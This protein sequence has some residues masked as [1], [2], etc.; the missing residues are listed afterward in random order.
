MDL[1]RVGGR[2]RRPLAQESVDQP[3]A[4]DDLVCVQE[5]VR[6]EDELP[7][8][9]ERDRAAVDDLERTENAKLRLS[10]PVLGYAAVYTTP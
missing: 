8:R 10:S 6:Q 4:R 1:E 9:A 3:I 2:R 5:Q 7:P